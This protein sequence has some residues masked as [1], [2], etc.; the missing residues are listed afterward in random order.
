MGP[1][2]RLSGIRLFVLWGVL[3]GSPGLVWGQASCVQLTGGCGAAIHPS[4]CFPDALGPVSW[5]DSGGSRP[6]Q[7]R[8]LANSPQS[9][10]HP[11]VGI[12]AP[13]VCCSPLHPPASPGPSVKLR[14]VNQRVWVDYDAPNYYCQN[15]GD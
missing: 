10:C 4:Q 5:Q 12:G 8:I 7:V 3:L 9:T 13:P 6:R 2:E 1:T 11:P 15:T 14:I